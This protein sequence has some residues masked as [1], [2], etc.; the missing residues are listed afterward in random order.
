[1]T[2]NVRSQFIDR[3]TP[4]E[5]AVSVEVSERGGAVL[6]DVDAV[7]GSVGRHLQEPVRVAPADGR[8]R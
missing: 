6:V 4:S 5:R 2:E 3:W 1:M 7:E 8:I